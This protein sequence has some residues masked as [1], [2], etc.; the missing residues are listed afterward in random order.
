MIHEA[1]PPRWRAIVR[2]LEEHR[3]E[4]IE[5]DK[6]RLVINYAGCDGLSFEISR[7]E[8]A[9]TDNR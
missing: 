3:A 8:E 7:K 5:A 9:A 4:I 1:D 6:G 2:W